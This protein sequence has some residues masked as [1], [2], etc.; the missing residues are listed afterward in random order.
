MFVKDFTPSLSVVRG[1]KRGWVP[2][3]LTERA[4]YSKL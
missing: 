2:L 1:N 4:T 3:T